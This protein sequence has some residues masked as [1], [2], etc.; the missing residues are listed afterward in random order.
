MVQMYDVG[1]VR[2][3]GNIVRAATDGMVLYIDGL[4]G[5]FT[6]DYNLF[7]T[8]YTMSSHSHL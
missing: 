8:L 4:T 5:S 6:S 7:D 1:N 2:F 3:K